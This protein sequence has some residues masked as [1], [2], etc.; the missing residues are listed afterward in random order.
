MKPFNV[1]DIKIWD[2]IYYKYWYVFCKL[3][4]VIYVDEYKIWLFFFH[5]WIYL[6][7]YKEVLTD[8]SWFVDRRPRWKKLLW[9][10]W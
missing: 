7:V 4:K 3:L 8:K 5:N 6:E 10:Y 2:V 1:N 9:I